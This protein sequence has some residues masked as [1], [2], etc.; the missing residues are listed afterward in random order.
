MDNKI[1]V[2]VKT[3]YYLRK[4]NKDNKRY[5]DE[6]IGTVVDHLTSTKTTSYT[7][8]DGEMTAEVTT[9]VRTYFDTDSFQ[10]KYPELYKEFSDEKKIKV[11]RVR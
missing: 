2:S 1:D 8:T 9:T 5:L 10:K 3:I 11:V 6:A 7:T 4:A